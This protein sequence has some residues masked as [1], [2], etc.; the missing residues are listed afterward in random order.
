MLSS[1]FLLI[2]RSVGGYFLAE[3]R[4]FGQ[5]QK[6]NFKEGPGLFATVDFDFEIGTFLEEPQVRCVSIQ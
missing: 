4:I 6:P 5:P 3:C 2:A 1:R